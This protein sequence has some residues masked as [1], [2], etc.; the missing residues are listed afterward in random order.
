MPEEL[1]L[2]WALVVS[3]VATADIPD[4]TIVVLENSN[5]A[6]GVYTRSE[7][8][9]VAMILN[10]ADLPVV[11][12]ATPSAVRR[13]SL[14]EYYAEIGAINRDRDVAKPIRLS[15]YQPERAYSASESGQLHTFLN[16]QLGRRYSVRGYVR[17]K[18]G[19]GIHCA[20]MVSTALCRT[21]RY[22]FPPNYSVSPSALV[23]Q[24][25]PSHHARHVTI[26]TREPEGTWCERS[27][28]WWSSCFDWC[29]WACWETLTF[30]R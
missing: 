10:L 28:Q 16:A 17:G 20:E 2:S 15:L 6:V 22:Q 26:R 18:P 8:T 12:E 24:I 4:G 7:I 9:H 11:Y 13:L 27:W 21:G 25:K 3:L 1:M 30:C 29:G 23:A 19:D 14:N 5:P